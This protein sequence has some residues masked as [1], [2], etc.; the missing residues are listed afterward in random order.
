VHER[1]VCPR[2]DDLLLVPRLR[3]KAIS[4]P[5]RSTPVGV[6]RPDSMLVSGRT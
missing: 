3:S 4:F 1:A 5:D 6:V 2:D